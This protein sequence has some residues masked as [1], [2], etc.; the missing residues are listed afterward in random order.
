M[1]NGKEAERAKGGGEGED[2]RRVW[3]I[4]VVKLSYLA[5]AL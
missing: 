5:S 3:N 4:S 2:G 1:G